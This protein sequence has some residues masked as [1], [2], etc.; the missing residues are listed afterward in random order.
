MRNVSVLPSD[1]IAELR[2]L[3][4]A[5]VA[6][7]VETFGVR[8]PN[9]GFTDP[10]IR[11]LSPDLPPMVGYA[12]TARIR[13]ATPSVEGQPYIERRDWLRHIVDI[14]EPRVVVVEDLD[15]PAGLGAL[16]GEMHVNILHASGCVGVVT[17][18]ALRGLPAGR[19]LGLQMFARNVSVSHAYAH[20][21]D[22]GGPV[23]VGR[24][25]VEPGDVL[26]GDLHGV[27]T[28]PREIAEQIPAAASQ[29]MQ[30]KHRI[31]ELCR[32]GRFSLDSFTA[33]QRT[34]N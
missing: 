25:K 5:T 16:I 11:C 17:N 20:I 8:L 4:S 10:T 13:T 30:Y 31:I 1:L 12:V 18:G 33:L 24:M 27:Q 19:S 15:N 9:T 34:Q 6:N 2:R 7:A 26:H 32:S 14:P 29:I 23:V 3:D 22:F 21:L 28:I